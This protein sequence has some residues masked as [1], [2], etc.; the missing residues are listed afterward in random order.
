MKY[1][2]YYNSAFPNEMKIRERDKSLLW[3]LNRAIAIKQSYVLFHLG[4]TANLLSVIR[5]I[6]ALA[7]VVLLHLSDGALYMLLGFFLIIWQVNLDFADGCLARARNA[8]D[9]YGT[10]IDGLA[11]EFVRV[12]MIL[13]SSFLI[14]SIYI[15]LVGIVILYS[16][17]IVHFRIKSEN[18]S[19]LKDQ[20]YLSRLFR[21]IN[22]VLFSNIFLPF[23]LLLSRISI[24]DTTYYYYSVLSVYLI[25]AIPL[26]IYLVKDH[27]L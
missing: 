22:G 17:Q 18:D 5:V 6:L 3:R 12:C 21:V 4:I 7:G 26:Y 16:T 1:K 10:I 11:N 13:I 25:A 9:P 23:I 27:K 14:G 15:F 19:Y 20:K 2:K 8:K 24:L